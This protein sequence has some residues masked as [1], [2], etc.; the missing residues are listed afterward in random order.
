MPRLSPTVTSELIQLD[1]AELI[2]LAGQGVAAFPPG[3]LR[4]AAD[5]CWDQCEATG[6]ARHCVLW[7]GLD[8]IARRFEDD[9]HLATR[10]VVKVDEALRRHLTD[11]LDAATALEGTLL[12]RTLRDEIVSAL[13]D[14]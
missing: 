8:L 14:A 1:K 5:Y 6:D 13:R 12:A 11:V 7:V 10:A 9:D 4:D 2:R 3:R